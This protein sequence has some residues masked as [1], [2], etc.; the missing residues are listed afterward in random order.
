MNEPSPKSGVRP[1][2]SV[3]A[4]VPTAA[5][6]SFLLALDEVSAG[7]EAGDFPPSVVKALGLLASRLDFVVAGSKAN[8]FDGEKAA[9]PLRMVLRS[10]RLSLSL[11]WVRSLPLAST[12]RGSLT[13]RRRRWNYADV[14]G[15]R[16]LGIVK[17]TFP[18]FNPYQSSLSR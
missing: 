3:L 11:R 9:Q 5:K 10:A 14:G 16:L 8:R 13:R 6:D 17:W 12:W 7:L 4:N 18:R 1:A 2:G 15:F